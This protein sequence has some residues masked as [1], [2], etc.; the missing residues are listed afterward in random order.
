MGDFASKEQLA[1][2]ADIFARAVT[3]SR[4]F[5]ILKIVSTAKN[6]PALPFSSSAEVSSRD[7][8]K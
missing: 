8:C 7:L 2:S 1:T 4:G 3:A 6:L 5:C